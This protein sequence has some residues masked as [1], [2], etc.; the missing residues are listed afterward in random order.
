MNITRDISIVTAFI[1][2]VVL[3]WCLDDDDDTNDGDGCC[4][5][6]HREDDASHLMDE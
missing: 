4:D 2:F 5:V 6:G 3:Y 1:D